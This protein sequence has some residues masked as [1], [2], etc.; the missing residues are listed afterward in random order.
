MYRG[1][2][3]M[4]VASLLEDEDVSDAELRRLQQLIERRMSEKRK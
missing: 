2:R 3:E 4:L 1:S